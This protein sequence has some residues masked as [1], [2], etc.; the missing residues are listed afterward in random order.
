[1][2]FG[3]LSAQK[4]SDSRRESGASILDAFE[5]LAEYFFELSA[6]DGAGRDADHDFS[7]GSGSLE[8]FLPIGLPRR[9]SESWRNGAQKAR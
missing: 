7:F 6:E 5:P 3:F 8:R 9:L 2:P 4:V 1:L